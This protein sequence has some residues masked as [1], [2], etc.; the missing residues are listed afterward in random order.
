M[1]K[2][3]QKSDDCTPVDVTNKGKKLDD[4]RVN[5]KLI[6]DK[7]SK[8]P[9]KNRK[10]GK[11]PKGE[12]NSNNPVRCKYKI[13]APQIPVNQWYVDRYKLAYSIKSPSECLFIPLVIDTEFT[14]KNRK[15]YVQKSRLGLTTQL[16]GIDRETPKSIFALD[17]RV[18]A[19][20]IL[21]GEKPL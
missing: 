2:K 21:D 18:N 4:N 10:D 20:R 7:K 19:G 5:T 6:K 14:D 11:N 15:E 16:C 12:E 1:S 9:S 8:K 17:P 3:Y 13:F